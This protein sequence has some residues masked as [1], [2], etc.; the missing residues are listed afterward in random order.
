MR[1][2]VMPDLQLLPAGISSGARQFLNAAAVGRKGRRLLR[3][4]LTALGR[5][6]NEPHFDDAEQLVRGQSDMGS[7]A[8]RRGRPRAFA[9][10]A[11][12]VGQ[13]VPALALPRMAERRDPRG[14]ASGNPAPRSLLWA[15]LG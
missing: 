6:S 8:S 3:R 9:A 15:R 5:W 7:H 14:R 10:S 13:E 4:E 12:Q 11:G 1:E 2:K